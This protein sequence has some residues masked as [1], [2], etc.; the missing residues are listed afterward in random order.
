[1]NQVSDHTNILFYS[2]F[3]EASKTFMNLLERVPDFKSNVTML[4]VDSKDIRD[5][6]KNDS[7]LKVN[8][9]PCLLRIHQN[10]GY[11]EMFEGT[12]AF[13]VLNVYLSAQEEAR[14]L[15]QKQ[16]QQMQAQL[17]A[18][19]QQMQAQLQ[20]QQQQ[21]QAQLHV[22]QQQLQSQQKQPPSNTATPIEDL[23]D[24][25][26]EKEVIPNNMTIPPPFPERAMLPDRVL[27]KIEHNK[28]G[29]ITNIALQ[30]Q[31]ER[32]QASSQ[33]NP[34]ANPRVL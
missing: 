4:C 34:N 2:K 31:K 12:R 14:K 32:E 7:K 10:N 24:E 11:V 18:Q 26:K 33:P 3:S 20:A 22:Q 29:S 30:M 23:L 9:L 1:M 15:L 5:R 27:K 6:I 28:N 16:Q 13:H 17:Q 19:Q 21:M 8:K 25:N